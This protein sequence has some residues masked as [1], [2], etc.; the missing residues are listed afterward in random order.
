MKQA[1]A[2]DFAQR[3]L[4]ATLFYDEEY[5]ALGHLSLVDERKARERF[6]ASFL[7]EEDTYI[8]ERATRWD[9][10]ESLDGVGYA[11][12]TVA[13]THGT[14]DTAEAAAAMLLKLARRHGLVPSF[15]LL[16]EESA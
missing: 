6:I 2:D 16:F 12:A 7:P 4:A 3:I 15:A 5:G 8:I 1:W 11:L 10:A 13:A 14:Y 9:E